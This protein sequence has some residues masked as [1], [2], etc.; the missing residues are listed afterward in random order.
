MA[1]TLKFHRK[2]HLPRDGI[3][4]FHAAFGIFAAFRDLRDLRPP[5]LT[6]LASVVRGRRET[7]HP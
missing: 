2:R 5:A 7:A 4:F 6:G 3:T 1:E